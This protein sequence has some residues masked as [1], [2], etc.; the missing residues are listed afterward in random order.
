MNEARL[1]AVRK[2]ADQRA[3]QAAA[4]GLA[5]EDRGPSALSMRIREPEEIGAT[6]LSSLSSLSPALK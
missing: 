6:A 5:S 1:G 2:E 4:S 3:P